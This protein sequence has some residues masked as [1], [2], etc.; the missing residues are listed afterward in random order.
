MRRVFPV[1]AALLTAAACSQ[2]GGG[3]DAG[4]TEVPLADPV[5][6]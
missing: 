1:L 2:D 6:Q 3:S 4:P 5:F